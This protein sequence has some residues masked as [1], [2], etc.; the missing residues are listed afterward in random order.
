MKPIHR[1]Q[2]VNAEPEIVHCRLRVRCSQRTTD[3]SDGWKH[4]LAIVSISTGTGES[5][6]SPAGMQSRTSPLRKLDSVAFFGFGVWSTN[7][8]I[9]PASQ[10]K[11]NA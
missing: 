10:G 2:A 7:A 11:K 5:R 3:G 8:G 9:M 4:S 1:N 6:C